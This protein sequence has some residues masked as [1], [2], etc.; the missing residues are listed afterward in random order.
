VTAGGTMN[1]ALPPPSWIAF[2][3]SK[4]LATVMPDRSTSP[5]RPVWIAH[6]T[7]ALQLPSEEVGNPEKLQVQPGLQLQNS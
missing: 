1:T 3:Q 7:R 5:H 4:M 6:P 2:G